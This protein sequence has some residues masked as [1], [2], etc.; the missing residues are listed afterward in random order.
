MRIAKADLAAAT[1]LSRFEI[2]GKHEAAELRATRTRC[3]SIVPEL[4]SAK[5]E[6]LAEAR[7]AAIEVRLSALGETW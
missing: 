3:L 1:D 4:H 6:H 5:A 7:V 2:M